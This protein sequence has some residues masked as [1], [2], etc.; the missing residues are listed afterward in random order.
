MLSGWFLARPARLPLVFGSF[1]VDW[2]DFLP[3]VPD[4]VRVENATFVAERLQAR[5]GGSLVSGEG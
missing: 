2:D 3:P 1:M 5:L 4:D